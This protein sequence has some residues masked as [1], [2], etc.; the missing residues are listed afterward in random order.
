[1]DMNHRP[2]LLA[3][4]A[5][6]GLSFAT[7]TAVQG[8]VPEREVSRTTTTTTRGTISEFGSGRIVV[9]N[10]TEKTPLG[11]TFTKT[12]TYEDEDGNPVS[13][14]TVKS[15]LPVTVYYTRDGD[16][17]VANR[18]VVRTTRERGPGGEETV[19]TTKSLGTISEFGRDAF[20]IRS[21]QAD[22]P[23]RYLYST[24]TRYVDEDGNPV[25]VETVKSGLPVTVYYTREGDRMNATR[26]VVHR[27]AEPGT[28]IRK[29]TTIT[30]EKR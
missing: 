13:V 2:N 18:V 25:S 17:M 28:I 26:V 22:R 4:A 19:T 20:E 30:E 24:K 27:A 16:S 12:T 1:M 29:K 23:V 7:V 6:L 14:E 8:Q 5:F 10:E 11:Y 3:L 21:E 15:G 9:R